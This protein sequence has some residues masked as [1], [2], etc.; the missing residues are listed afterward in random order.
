MD[1]IKSTIDSHDISP[2]AEIS[3]KDSISDLGIVP[4]LDDEESKCYTENFAIIKQL[5]VAS[6]DFSLAV[7][8]EG[9]TIIKIGDVPFIIDDIDI[10]DPD[11]TIKTG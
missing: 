9:D 5:L 1:D 7:S 3:D 8:P 6:S 11:K 10:H 4:S 2:S